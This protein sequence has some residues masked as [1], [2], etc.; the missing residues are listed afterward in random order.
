MPRTLIEQHKWSRG[1]RSLQGSN[2]HLIAFQLPAELPATCSERVRA[3]SRRVRLITEVQTD[4][5]W[6]NTREDSAESYLWSDKLL[7]SSFLLDATH[8]EKDAFSRAE[9]LKPGNPNL[10][11]IPP[12]LPGENRRRS[13]P[14]SRQ[15]P[16]A[17]QI[18]AMFAARGVPNWSKNFSVSASLRRCLRTTGEMALAT[19]ASRTI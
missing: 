8:T 12:Q 13:S 3:S 14:V 2:L 10:F 16:S 15:R 5:V 6:Q 19:S 17:T 18:R 11:D 4:S 1:P 7:A 9:P